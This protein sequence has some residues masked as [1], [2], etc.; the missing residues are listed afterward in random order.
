MLPDLHDF[1]SALEKFKTN[2]DNVQLLQ[3]YQP[4]TG[5][6]VAQLMNVFQE[7]NKP[8]LYHAVNNTISNELFPYSYISNGKTCQLNLTH[9]TIAQ[10]Q[11]L[12]DSNSL[13]LNPAFLAILYAALISALIS[14]PVLLLN[15]PRF[16][17]LP[18]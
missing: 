16:T 4:Q 18:A 9:L 12:K 14:I 3:E 7:I 11:G 2:P 6:D 8:H 10:L 13:K 15:K 17:L 5:E 1:Q